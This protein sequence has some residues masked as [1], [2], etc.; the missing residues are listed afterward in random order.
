MIADPVDGDQ[1]GQ[2]GLARVHQADDVR[3]PVEG[4]LVGAVHQIESARVDRSESHVAK[5]LAE[6]TVGDV[7]PPLQLFIYPGRG[8]SEIPAEEIVHGSR[9]RP[10]AGHSA[11]TGS[12]RGI[13][14]GNWTIWGVP[15]ARKV[16]RRPALAGGHS[17][18]AA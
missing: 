12:V 2:R 5:P 3:N 4:E 16:Y 13:W 9:R 11:A 10:G 6:V 17:V 18:T 8:W 1:V 7:R 15:E 14:A